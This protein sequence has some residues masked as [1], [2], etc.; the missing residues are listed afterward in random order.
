M[1][2]DCTLS[3]EIRDQW[4]LKRNTI[5]VFGIASESMWTS[6]NDKKPIR[7]TQKEFGIHIL[8]REIDRYKEDPSVIHCNFPRSWSV[9]MSPL[10]TD[11]KAMFRFRSGEV[12]GGGTD[13]DVVVR[14]GRRRRRLLD[15]HPVSTSRKLLNH[16]VKSKAN[17]F[18]LLRQDFLWKNS[19]SALKWG[20]K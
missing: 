2:C 11:H 17:L 8:Y 18:D 19:G 6:H 5:D 1:S 14:R 9:W 13:S 15:A 7:R 10:W 3:A 12:D 16:P 20:N 4:T